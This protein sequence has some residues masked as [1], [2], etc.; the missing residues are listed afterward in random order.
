MSILIWDGRRASP[1]SART[2]VAFGPQ[3]TLGHGFNTCRCRCC[4]KRHQ[5]V[6]RTPLHDCLALTHLTAAE[7]APNSVTLRA[8]DIAHPQQEEP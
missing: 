1:S 3:Q 6:T 7:G 2:A 8:M 5:F 4:N